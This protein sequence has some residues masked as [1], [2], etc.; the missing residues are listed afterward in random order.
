MSAAATEARQI[1]DQVTPVL[2]DLHFS[3][4]L[5]RMVAD[6]AAPNPYG[7]HEVC[8]GQR[9][10]FLHTCEHKT[11]EIESAMADTK[12]RLL[13]LI[14]SCGLRI[15]QLDTLEFKY[16][17][18]I[19]RPDNAFVWHTCLLP[20]DRI[21]MASFGAIMFVNYKGHLMCTEK[22]NVES[23]CSEFTNHRLY[24]LG[25]QSV[26]VF[27]I[28]STTITRLL[29]FDVNMSVGSPRS[30]AY[31][32]T[33][34]AVLLG[35]IGWVGGLYSFTMEDTVEHK[36]M[37]GSVIQRTAN[38]VWWNRVPNV[39]GTGHLLVHGSY[40]YSITRTNDYVV[41]RSSRDLIKMDA[42]G[43]DMTVTAMTQHTGSQLEFPGVDGSVVKLQAHKRPKILNVCFDDSTQRVLVVTRE[44]YHV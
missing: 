29:T 8:L 21:A 40:V 13:F 18:K 6:Y 44:F 4:S 16:H 25:K 19:H 42:D 14:A 23:M 39:V 33:T 17:F 15:H 41:D 37:N 11:C 26:V 30:I 3:A 2:T 1:L 27:V 20:Y 24:V 5:V 7:I 38:P 22:V 12:R 34:R 31:D 9:G 28:A 36:S 10:P 43:K 32:P 35:L